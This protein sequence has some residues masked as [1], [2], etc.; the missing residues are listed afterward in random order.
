MIN[1]RRTRKQRKRA[2]KRAT[3][4]ENAARHGQLRV[5]K[6]LIEARNEKARRDLDAHRVGDD[7]EG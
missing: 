1:L 3:A 4:S 2:E 5:R 6:S 7:D